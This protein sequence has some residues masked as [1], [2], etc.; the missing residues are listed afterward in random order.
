MASGSGVSARAARGTANNSTNAR[1]AFRKSGIALSRS[2]SLRGAL[3][4][5]QSILSLGGEMDCFAALAMT[6][7]DL[8][9]T[10]QSGLCR[11]LLGQVFGDLV[12]KAGGG[13]PALVGTD[14]QRQILGHV[15][16]FD[17]VDADL[18]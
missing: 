16:G 8:R 3:A 7:M 13:E 14:Q 12:E 18:L 10:A 1:V 5:K 4:T 17:G 2:L 11:H 9:V 15:A 6:L